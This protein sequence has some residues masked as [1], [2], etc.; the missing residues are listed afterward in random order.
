M[1]KKFIKNMYHKTHAQQSLWFIG[2][3]YYLVSKIEYPSPSGFETMI[4]HADNRGNVQDWLEL[5][6]S[7][8]D[9]THKQ[10]VDKFYKTQ[11]QYES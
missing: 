10:S 3:N 6:C 11:V 2:S 5:Y 7:R 1:K 4:F 8:E 9:E